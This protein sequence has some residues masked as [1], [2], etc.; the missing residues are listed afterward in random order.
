MIDEDSMCLFNT[1]LAIPLYGDDVVLLLKSRGGLQRCLNKVYEFCTSSSLEVNLLKIKL[2]IY[3]RN[4]RQLNQ[5]A[6]FID[7]DQ[8]KINH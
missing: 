1:M 8:I 7:K 3:G 6:Y 5:E 4:K 2:M